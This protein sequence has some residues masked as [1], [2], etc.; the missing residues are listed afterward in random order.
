MTCYV[1]SGMLNLTHS[2]NCLCVC[3]GCNLFPIG[4]H[5][6]TLTD[7]IW[8][9]YL[10]SWASWAKK[11]WGKSTPACLA[12]SVLI[13][14]CE[15]VSPCVAL[16]VFMSVNNVVIVVVG[17]CKV[18]WVHCISCLNSCHFYRLI[19]VV[20][21]IRLCILYMCNN[22]VC[23]PFHFSSILC[24]ALSFFRRQLDKASAVH[25]TLIFPWLWCGFYE[26]YYLPMY[27]RCSGCECVRSR[28]VL[29]HLGQELLLLLALLGWFSS[30]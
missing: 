4:Q 24:I 27:V 10:I 16:D 25:C 3:S 2:L 11:Y 15:L 21:L 17:N 22:A 20:R 14:P 29:V 23:L 30:S 18:I 9:A 19:F 1:W 26:K 12:K 13:Y 7:S 5:P 8:P 28:L 6:D